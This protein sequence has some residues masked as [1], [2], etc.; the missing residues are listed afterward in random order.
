MKTGVKTILLALALF[1]VAMFSGCTPAFADGFQNQVGTTTINITDTNKLVFPNGAS[2]LTVTNLTWNPGQPYTD[3]GG[4]N[5][6]GCFTNVDGFY[7]MFDYFQG[8][9]LW[10]LDNVTNLVSEGYPFGSANIT[11]GWTF[12][13]NF[14]I[15]NS[16]IKVTL[17]GIPTNVSSVVIGNRTFTSP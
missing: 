6:V 16:T 11:N 8:S 14:S 12:P 4:T 1:V 17:S 3:G 10:A 15:T 9:G 13:S 2:F 5:H 7:V